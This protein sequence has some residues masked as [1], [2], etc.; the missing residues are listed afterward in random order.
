MPVQIGA[1]T[2]SFSDPTGLLSDCHRRIETFLVSLEAVAAA[3]DQRASED[4]RR[5]LQTA[6][7]YFGQ[8]APKHTADEESSLFPR[9]R[10]SRHPE[11]QSSLS[12]LDKLEEEHHL[13]APLHAEVE[14]LGTKYLLAGSLADA[15][16]ERF[17]N[18]VASLASLYK[19]HINVE[20]SVV[21]PLA[22]RL[23]TQAEKMEVAEEMANRRGLAP[24]V[25]NEE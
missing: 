12:Q 4:T 13:A 17:R 5:G 2:H 22:A 1:K 23:L 24:L 7:Q 3:I 15:E 25:R 18:A 9:M 11:I 14:L 21:F 16:V 19:H 6:L 20:D 8:A 10:R